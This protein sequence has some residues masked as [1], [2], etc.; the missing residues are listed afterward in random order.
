[1]GILIDTARELE[2]ETQESGRNQID[3]WCEA[4]DIEVQDIDALTHSMM[5]E[6]LEAMERGS[7]PSRAIQI[8][9]L[10]CLYIGFEAAMR[11]RAANP[12]ED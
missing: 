12:L 1:M 5:R 11:N 4:R 9:S 3:E 8:V 2:D 6:F 7:P 10:M